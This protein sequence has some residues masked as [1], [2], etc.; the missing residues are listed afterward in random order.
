M[1]RAVPRVTV[2]PPMEALPKLLTDH[3]RAPDVGGG[4]RRRFPGY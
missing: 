4:I 3:L 2:R 1:A